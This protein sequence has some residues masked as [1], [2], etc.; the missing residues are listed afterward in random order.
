MSC[1]TEASHNTNVPETLVDTD[2]CCRY[3]TIDL[4]SFRI[5]KIC[6]RPGWQY[7]TIK[8]LDEFW[9]AAKICQEVLKNY[10]FLLAG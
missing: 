7:W 9:M 3:L 1:V 4:C 5:M 6:A 8:K 10:I 2:I